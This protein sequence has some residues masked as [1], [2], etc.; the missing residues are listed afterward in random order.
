[1]NAQFGAQLWFTLASVWGSIVRREVPGG[2]PGTKRGWA[3]NCR[4]L[5]ENRGRCDTR[6]IKNMVRYRALADV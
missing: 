4:A 6:D 1:V 3:L 2:R 5:V